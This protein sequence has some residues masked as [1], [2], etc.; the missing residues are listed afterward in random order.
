[1]ENL[2]LLSLLRLV[3]KLESRTASLEIKD[4]GMN[5]GRHVSDDQPIKKPF[6][7]IFP[8]NWADCGDVCEDD[9]RSVNDD[10]AP[11]WVG[12][13]RRK[14]KKIVE[15]LRSAG[16]DAFQSQ[17]KTEFPVK[18]LVATGPSNSSSGI[19]AGVSIARKFVCHVDN[20]GASC[21][22]DS[23]SE[24]LK[25]NNIEVTSCFSSKSWMRLD[26]RE[27]VT[28]FRVCVPLRFKDRVMNSMLWP[29]GVMLRQWI[30]K[31]KNGNQNAS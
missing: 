27:L 20:L 17:R 28:S 10:L 15:G 6:V 19:E 23:V 7:G 8:E 29:T 11:Q 31:P 2:D 1:V 24:F 16:R 18:K 30:F 25:E 12:V 9:D 3:E 22:I 21:T 13:G 26:E 4:T 5:V 14:S